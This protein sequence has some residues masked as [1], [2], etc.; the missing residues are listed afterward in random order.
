MRK[1]IRLWKKVIVNRT[2][3]PFTLAPKLT[4]KKSTILYWDGNLKPNHLLEIL[5]GIVLI[6]TLH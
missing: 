3:A 6:K 1:D 5:F 4:F 2:I